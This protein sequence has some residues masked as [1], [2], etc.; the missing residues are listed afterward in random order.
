[1]AAAGIYG[2]MAFAVSQRTQE[3]GIRMALGARGG[4][5]ARMVA[6]Q[7]TWMVGTGAAVGIVFALIMA[8]VL[9]SA[10]VGTSAINPVALAG[11]VATLAAAAALATLIPTRRAV[12]IDPVD[13]LRSE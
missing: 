13:A 12:R 1:M 8:R 9:A 11:V 5:V 4:D 2:V 3:I 7:A 6:R 10:L